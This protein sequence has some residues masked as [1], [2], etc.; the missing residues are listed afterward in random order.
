MAIEQNK[1]YTLEEKARFRKELEEAEEQFGVDTFSASLERHKQRW[2]RRKE[3]V[4]A[5]IA[6]AE[7]EEDKERWRQKLVELGQSEKKTAESLAELI[8]MTAQTKL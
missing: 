3:Q 1:Q 5:Q 6:S 4:L 2:Q 7:A 8:V